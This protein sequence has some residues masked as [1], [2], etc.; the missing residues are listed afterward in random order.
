MIRLYSQIFEPYLGVLEPEAL[1]RSFKTALK[2]LQAEKP[3]YQSG[4]P[5]WWGE[6]IKRTAVDAGAETHVV[7]KSLDRMV[8]QLLRRFS[9]KEGYKLFDDSLACLHQL[10]N[11]SVKTGLVSNT[12]K[13]MLAVLDDLGITTY[14]D[15]ILI[16]EVEGLEKPS[17]EIYARA[18]SRASVKR[19]ETLHVGDELQADFHGA[20][21]AGLQALLLRRP[22]PEGE[23]EMKEPD[24]E[25]Q[26]VEVAG[27]LL[28]VVGRVLRSMSD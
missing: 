6:V 11:L 1:K 5:E 26:G 20:R 19:N 16:S 15:P 10:K 23:G 2:Q 22:G 13:R 8:P 24:E 28:D 27:S 18:C 4:A 12:D 17:A 9:S 25:L 14:L 3:V 7:D 21:K